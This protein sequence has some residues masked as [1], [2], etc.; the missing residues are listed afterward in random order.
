VW[1]AFFEERQWRTAVLVVQVVLTSSHLCETNQSFRDYLLKG[2]SAVLKD[3]TMVA[4]LLK[5]HS[6]MMAEYTTSEVE[7]TYKVLRLQVMSLGVVGVSSPAYL[8]LDGLQEKEQLVLPIKERGNSNFKDGRYRAAI[9]DY[10]RA[11][12]ISPF[13]AVLYSN[14]S[15]CY[16]KNGDTWNACVDSF[17]ALVL[18]P[19]WEKPYHRC[20]EAWLALGNHS[21][22]L[23]MNNMGRDV[24]STT[25]ELS[26]QN[27]QI[28]VA[29]ETAKGGEAPPT[30][31]SHQSPSA[32]G[33]EGV[34]KPSSKPRKKG[35]KQRETST[36]TSSAH[37]S[38]NSN[39]EN[40]ATATTQ[41][42]DECESD[43]DDITEGLTNRSGK[44]DHSGTERD[45]A[46]PKREPIEDQNE[47]EFRHAITAKKMLKRR[48]RDDVI[49]PQA[50]SSGSEPDEDYVGAVRGLPCPER[51]AAMA[52]RREERDMDDFRR[53]EK[54]REGMRVERKAMRA[55]EENKIVQTLLNLD[56]YMK[57]QKLQAPTLDVSVTTDQLFEM[58]KTVPSRRGSQMISGQYTAHSE[59][60]RSLEPLPPL[61]PPVIPKPPASKVTATFDEVRA[62]PLTLC[63]QRLY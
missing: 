57:F 15:L 19:D 37:S 38:S 51:E 2:E 28:L 23:K 1:P 54:E 25:S 34:K 40:V 24:C 46:V 52:A 42:L 45:E 21:L 11:I 60:W 58:M 7:V 14:R 50:G 43:F 16:L 12:R 33:E 47:W 3:T 41:H 13:S 49:I 55:A 31:P 59:G 44:G 56:P 22:A 4:K 20:S 29:M 10:T 35:R 36:P 9:G 18:R 53:R 39:C 32:T 17:R 27:E 5:L 30:G 26:R 62:P 61:S 48:P 6:K 8:F 63:R